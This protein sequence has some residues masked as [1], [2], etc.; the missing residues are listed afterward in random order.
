MSFDSQCVLKL[1]NFIL[2]DTCFSKMRTFCLFWPFPSRIHDDLPL[3]ESLLLGVII[4][5]EVIGLLSHLNDAF[6]NEVEVV[7]YVVL[8][9]HDLV[10]LEVFDGSQR[11]KL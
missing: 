8:L 1:S 6:T 4:I 5:C 2:L 7:G 3:Q 10:L 11:G 9:D